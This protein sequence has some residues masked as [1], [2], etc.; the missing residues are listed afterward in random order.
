[1]FS[2]WRTTTFS[3]IEFSGN[4]S[5]SLVVRNLVWGVDI[6]LSIIIAAPMGFGIQND[7]ASLFLQIE[8]HVR[9]E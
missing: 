9:A 6:L 5:N 3:C 8:L 4:K 7:E 2:F 1:M